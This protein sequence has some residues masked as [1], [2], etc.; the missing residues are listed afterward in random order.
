[1]DISLVVLSLPLLLPLVLLVALLIK[2]DTPGPA[3]FIQERVGSRRQSENGETRWQVQ[4]FRVYKF[5][6]M[7]QNADQSVHQ[8]YIK[9]FVEG[10]IKITQPGHDKFKLTDDPRVTR[11]GRLLRKASFDELPQ[12]INV[13]KGEMSLVG[14]RPVPPYE[15]DGYEARHRERLAALPGMTGLW[16]VKGRCLVS[17]EEMMQMDIKYVRNQSPW[18]DIK[19]LFQTIPA[20]LSG[21]GAE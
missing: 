16:Q 4:N 19:I 2:L 11:I 6:T 5:R 3:L 14:P 12:L 9:A 10:R 20:I 13:I 17:F 8:A 18:L 1:M 15:V 7:F 21:R